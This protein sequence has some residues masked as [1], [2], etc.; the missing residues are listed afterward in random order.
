[1]SILKV[2]RMG[3]P[4]L[5]ATARRVEPTEVRRPEFQ[6]LI[7]D[8]METMHEY[9]GIGLAAPQVHENVRLVIVGVQGD[10][11]DDDDADIKVMPIINPEITPLDDEVVDGW[12]GCLS[13]PEVRGR[14]PRAPRIRIQGLDRRGKPI[15]LEMEGFPARVAQHETDHLDGILFIDRMKSLDTLTYMDEYAKFW[16]RTES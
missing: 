11:Q 3:N 12:E 4:V 10:D 8:M 9:R 14:V 7:D 13:I 1:M 16:A 6:K 2:A 15:S 5:R